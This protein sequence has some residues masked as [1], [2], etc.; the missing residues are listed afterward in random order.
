MAGLSR[1][2]SIATI[3]VSIAGCAQL[4]RLPAHQLMPH[5][6]DPL[7]G[8]SVELTGVMK[9]PAGEIR[10]WFGSDLNP[11]VRG[12]LAEVFSLDPNKNS[13][14]CG[15]RLT[16]TVPVDGSEVSVEPGVFVVK[17]VVRE[18]NP[19]GIDPRR[20]S[21]REGFG[22]DVTLIYRIDVYSMEQPMVASYFC[23]QRHA[24]LSRES[25]FPD[26]SELKAQA[27]GKLLWPLKNSE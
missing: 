3:V 11:P 25:A 14:K 2:F 22:S 27:A 16:K 24:L 7:V 6:Q 23:Q 17:K 1:L 4:A 15:L 20:A 10:A 8:S 19:L 12:A 13:L 21:M 5:E 18:S 9:V 26:P